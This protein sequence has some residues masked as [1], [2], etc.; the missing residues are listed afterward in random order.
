MNTSL[1]PEYRVH[2]VRAVWLVC[3]LVAARA[4]FLLL[5]DTSWWGIN[6][7]QYLDPLFAGLLIVATVVG[8]A[9]AISPSVKQDN[10]TV[11]L[12]RPWWHTAAFVSA[13]GIV[14][15]FLAPQY[16]FLGD[17][18][19]FLGEL[20]RFQSLGE[21]VSLHKEPIPMLLAEGTLWVQN[22]LNFSPVLRTTYVITGTLCGMAFVW[23]TIRLAYALFPQRINR[24]L[25]L[26]LLLSC[27]GTL[28]FF[29]YVE[30][31]AVPYVF[32]LGYFLGGLRFLKGRLS[33]VA[34]VGLLLLC[35]LGHFQHLLLIPSLGALLVMKK[36]GEGGARLVYRA[37]VFALPLLFIAYF[38]ISFSPSLQ[39]VVGKTFIPLQSS[40][41]SH[42]TLFSSRHGLDIFNEHLLLAAVPMLLIAA[43]LLFFRSRLNWLEPD[44]V[45]IVTA[46]VFMEALLVGG[47]LEL[48]AARDWDVTS[49]LGPAIALLALLLFKQISVAG[50]STRPLAIAA[51]S[52]AL[53][54]MVAWLVLNL[55]MNT[56]VRRFTDLI[57]S[58]RPLLSRAVTR[59]GYEDLRK[60][61]AGTNDIR[62]ELKIDK[63]MLETLP[64]P[65]DAMRAISF[66]EQHKKALGTEGAKELQNIV[67]V[68]ESLPDSSLQLEDAGDD[69][70]IR[71]GPH[72]SGDFITLGDAFELGCMQLW[73]HYE[74]TSLDQVIA[75][76]DAFIMLHP[77]LPNGF[78]LKGRAYFFKDEYDSSEVYLDHAIAEDPSRARPYFFRSHIAFR[79]N[80]FDS[81]RAD[82]K[83]CLDRD[84][85][86][87]AAL[88]ALSIMI[89]QHS[90]GMA[91]GEDIS[92]TIRRLQLFINR[93]SPLYLSTEVISGARESLAMVK[94]VQVGMLP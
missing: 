8:V 56:A 38:V 13:C 59:F 52:V 20:W 25:T 94:R 87:Y 36:R 5:P 43:F 61:Y 64:W 18:S 15:W 85:L 48:G 70:N 54:G 31:Y 44:V 16:T 79:R 41:G 32:A 28:L 67:G 30:T 35:I 10:E 93:A 53:A 66:M 14:F 47:F 27:G 9:W 62:Q 4:V 24:Y 57:E 11:R 19:M 71:L 92:T 69:G 51:S 74:F 60:Y 65:F 46:I 42:Y 7:F 89:E 21:Q 40:A 6:H 34:V 33:L 82:I 1:D 17:S 12:P 55:S 63:I 23:V 76:A 91:D 45:F 78:E 50:V 86:Y 22:A 75:R 3:T 73:Q 84:S 68:I 2:I 80:D 37:L 77:R 90:R 58:Y 29:G 39:S 83:R 88:S 81:A 49:A 26:A 72:G